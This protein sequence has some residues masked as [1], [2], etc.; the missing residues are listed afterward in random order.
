MAVTASAQ[1]GLDALRR[2]TKAFIDDDPSTIVLIP[3][4]TRTQVPGGGY[5]VTPG[6]PRAAQRFKLVADFGGD[7]ITASDGA[8]IHQWSYTLIGMWDSVIEIGDS[9]VD[10]DTTYTVV[11]LLQ[12]NGYEKRATVTASGR[13]PNYG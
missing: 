13:E 3:N 1:R 9:W 12:N 2:V 11:S 6:T 4:S 8:Q 10:G 5:D 7:G